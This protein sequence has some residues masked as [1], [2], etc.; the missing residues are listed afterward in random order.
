MQRVGL[1]GAI[2]PVAFADTLRRDIGPANPALHHV[3]GLQTL[4]AAPST[5]LP[6]G[7]SLRALQRLPDLLNPSGIFEAVPDGEDEQR[8]N[9]KLAEAEAEH[10]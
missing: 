2:R 5:A 7:S 9:N 3:L 8:E 4:C 6:L 1:P 10:C